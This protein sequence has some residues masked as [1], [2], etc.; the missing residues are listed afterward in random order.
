MKRLLFFL[1]LSASSALAS[2]S[3]I[4]DGDL[5]KA[6]EPVVQALDAQFTG[7]P[8]YDLPSASP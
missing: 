3:W 6:L 2:L 5:D 4:H 7:K 8:K 1:F